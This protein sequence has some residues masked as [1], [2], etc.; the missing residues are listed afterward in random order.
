MMVLVGTD[1]VTTPVDP[2]VTRLWEVTS[3]APAY[4]VELVAAEHQT[5]TD[6]C[7]YQDA[8]PG[9]PDVPELIISTIDDFAVEG[10][11][12]GDM[13]DARAADITNTYAVRFLDQVLRGGPPIDPAVMATPDDV[14]FDTR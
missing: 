13:D 12:P 1:D 5:F 8:V 4:R 10:C 2:N 3:N 6:I 9:L 14:I 11:S 7:A